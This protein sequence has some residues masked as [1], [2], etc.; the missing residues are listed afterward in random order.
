MVETE[1]FK[2]WVTPESPDCTKYKVFYDGTE[3][4]DVLQIQRIDLE[5]WKKACEEERRVGKGE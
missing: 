3:L 1:P 4:K 5:A 2:Y